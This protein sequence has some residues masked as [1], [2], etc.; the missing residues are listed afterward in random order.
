MAVKRI[1]SITSK[2]RASFTVHTVSDDCIDWINRKDENGTD[3]PIRQFCHKGEGDKI[4]LVDGMTASDMIAFDLVPLTIDEISW[5]EDQAVAHLDAS[6][7]GNEGSRYEN[8]KGFFA[9]RKAIVRA[10]N[11][12]DA[13]DVFEGPSLVDLFVGLAPE[14]QREIGRVALRRSMIESPD[15]KKS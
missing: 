10:R 12:F 15:K 5:A 13:G 14:I 11:V 1:A 9:F 8:L 7:D 6:V 3:L 4:P 2:D